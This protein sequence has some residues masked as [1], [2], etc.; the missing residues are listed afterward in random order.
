MVAGKTRMAAHR[1]TGARLSITRKI[2]NSLAVCALATVGVIAAPQAAA[3]E[4]NMVLFGDSVLADPSS[5]TYLA[6]RMANGSSKQRPGSCPN[7]ADNFGK[8]AARK[9]G[10]RARDFSCAGAVSMSKGP[11]I[12]GQV[13]AAIASGALNRS[14]RRVVFSTGFNDT[15]NNRSLS[16]TQ[17]R[18]RWVR[19]NAPQIRRI[20][21]AAPNARVQ[22]VGYPDIA[23][24]NKVCLF[25]IAPNVYDRTHLPQIGKWERNAQSMQVGLAR[26]TGTEFLD[27]K[28]STR[29]N[30]MCAP[31][32]KRYWAGLVDFYAGPGNLPVHIN[33]R[34][35]EHV[36]NVIAR[37]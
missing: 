16:S 17:L 26:A 6:G 29:D 23:A 22:I 12:S 28:R 11:Q 4:R 18:D 8:R 9:L 35:H 32:H 21:R 3:A 33:K 30:N 7:S 25:H 15:Y 1:T 36:A 10:L 2:V 14:T 24:G 13:D 5:P 19:Y 34:G 20:K 31:D 37:S 27:L